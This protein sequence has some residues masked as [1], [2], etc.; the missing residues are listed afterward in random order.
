MTLKRI[1]MMASHLIIADN[2]RCLVNDLLAPEVTGD[3][4]DLATEYNS[5]TD[6]SATAFTNGFKA[7]QGEIKNSKIVLA[8][9]SMLACADITHLSK[10][11]LDARSFI[12]TND[13]GSTS[14]ERKSNSLISRWICS[15]GRKSTSVKNSSNEG[16]WIE[17]GKILTL[18]V[19]LGGGNNTTIV[20]HKY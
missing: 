6:N 17:R 14:N 1:R 19:T 15:S 10:L 18:G 16:I 4:A 2:M 8:V 20:T 7:R 11:A 3:L 13:L 9:E 5:G 12:H